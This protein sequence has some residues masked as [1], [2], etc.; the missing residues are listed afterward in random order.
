MAE[1]LF[2]P[3]LGQTVDEVTLINWFVEDGDKVDF[4]DP[5]LEV[6]TD[7]AIFNV[8]ANAKGFIHIGPFSIGETLSVLTVVATIGEENDV[9]SPS[10]ESDQHEDDDIEISTHPLSNTVIPN[11]ESREQPLL[12]TGKV[13]ASP[14][15]R[16][17][18]REKHVDVALVSPTGGGG[19]RVMEE[20]VIAFLH[21]SPKASPLAI[22]LANE[23]GLELTGLPGTGPKGKITRDDVTKAVRDKL[24]SISSSTT[25]NI[26][27]IDN[28]EINVGENIPLRS[29]RK[30]IFDRM[31]ASVHSTARVTLITEVDATELAAYREQLNKEKTKAWGFKVS[32]N[33]LIGMIVTNALVEFPYMNARLS[34]DENFIEILDDINLGIA[35]D[36][37]RGLIVPVIRNANLLRL[38]DFGQKFRE[39]VE[40]TKKKQSTTEDLTGG[41]F[42]ITNLGSYEID[43]FTPVI[44]LPE[45]AILGIGRI[46]DKVVPYR[47]EI[48]V[49]KIVTLSLVFDHRLIDGAP[50]S[51]FLQYIKDKIENTSTAILHA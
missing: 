31:S 24:S 30:L 16:K 2:I 15:A 32:Y 20:D 46:Q 22:S 50:A 3:K 9:F 33:D 43:A 37:D 49:R 26:Q 11:R 7:K 14:R 44:N 21:H 48:T 45:A 40:R 36:T 25:K 10:T 47:R 6:E 51:R 4:G 41:T 35:V 8:E 19:V 39:L 18:A 38:Q 13:F 23:V 5:V 42:T 29:V 17:L 28:N 12:D 27:L 34:S 1:D